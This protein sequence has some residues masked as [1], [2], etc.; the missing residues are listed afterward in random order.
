M[1]VARVRTTVSSASMLV[2]TV[3]S[4]VSVAV[5]EPAAKE[6]VLVEPAALMP[7]ESVSKAAVPA[8]V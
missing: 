3:G 2:S 4:T 6:M 7:V 1:P 8:T 5:D